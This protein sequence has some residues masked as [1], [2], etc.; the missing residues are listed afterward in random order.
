MGRER[1]K[2]RE[3]GLRSGK[4]SQMKENRFKEEKEDIEKERRNKR[5]R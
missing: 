2:G 5:R 1:G 3:E 4:G